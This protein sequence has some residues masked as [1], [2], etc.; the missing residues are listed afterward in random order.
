MLDSHSSQELAFASRL[1]LRSSGKRHASTVIGEVTETTPTP[2]YKFKKAYK[3]FTQKSNN[4]KTFT[5]EEALAIFVDLNLTKQQYI[6]LR[7]RLKEK[8]I[9]VF[10]S[11]DV[12]KS[13][14]KECYPPDHSIVITESSAEIKMLALLNTTTSRIVQVQETVLQQCIN[15]IQPDS[16]E[17]VYKWGF[18]GSSGQKEYK[19]K[20]TDDKVC[21]SN[22]LMTSLVPIQLY[23]LQNN[24]NEKNNNMEKSMSIINYVLQTSSI[25]F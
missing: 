7:Q 1:S 4:N 23:G 25:S 18:D 6:T 5:P 22:L 14:K 19:Q 17:C 16:V 10:P 13:I 21:D 12:I 11:Y 2:A 20:L 9:N 3:M 15:D 24:N 8:E